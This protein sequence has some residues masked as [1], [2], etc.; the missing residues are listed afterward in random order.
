MKNIVYLS[1]FGRLK[2]G[3]GIKVAITRI[4]PKPSILGSTKDIIFINDLAPS[5]DLLTQYKSGLITWEEYECRFLEEAKDVKFMN[6]LKYL[7][8]L[9]KTNDITLYCYCRDKHCHRYI[10]G[11]MFKNIGYEVKEI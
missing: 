5:F 6:M 1:H 9:L 2:K 11:R 4:E 8:T 7:L 10:L 3:K